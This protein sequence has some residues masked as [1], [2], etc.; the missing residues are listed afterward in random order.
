M[1][2]DVRRRLGKKLK[3]GLVTG[4]YPPLQGG[5]GAF[6]QELGQ[7][8]AH[9][10]HEIHII[11][12]AAARPEQ[13]RQPVDGL[14]GLVEHMEA[15]QEPFNLPFAKLHPQTKRW[16]WGDV[17]TVADIT[18]R[19][20]LD[21]VNIQY[22]PAAYNMNSPAV[23]FLP[24]RLKGLTTPVVTFHDVRVPY[25]FP[26]AGRLREWV[27]QFMARQMAGGIATNPADLAS[28]R[29]QTTRPVQ[30]IPIG[31]NIHVYQPHP[32]ELQEVRDSFKLQPDDVL[33]GYFG[34]LNESKGADVLLKA[35]AQLGKKYH[36]V[37]IGGRT[38]SSD[39][40]NNQIFWNQLD[41]LIRAYHLE[42]RVFWTGYISD[43]R[44]STHLQAVDLMVMPYKDGVSLRRGTLM[45]ALAHGRPLLTT[46]P[47]HPV[48]EIVH[49]ENSWLVP[50]ND[51][52]AV[53]AGVKFLMQHPEIRQRLGQ[54]GAEIAQQFSWEKIAQKTAAFFEELIHNKK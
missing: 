42:K 19:F 18:G 36:L 23:Q 33:L 3:I 8:L 21:V 10:G 35:L 41:Q 44:V 13:K 16:W 53:T 28:L 48:P 11:T 34:F 15:R 30:E 32:I 25:L 14:W 43:V 39:P 46:L 22:Q 26:K 6:T 9:Q 45:A 7:A 12:S 17:R 2:D 37:F 52:E 40:T 29:Q 20:G 50:V 51:V 54:G 5:V 47:A 1:K 31:S 38:G 27:V 49:G 4:E 24:W